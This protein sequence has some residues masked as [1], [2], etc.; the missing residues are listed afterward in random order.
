MGAVRRLVLSSFIACLVALGM[1]VSPVAANAAPGDIGYPGGSFTGL[2]NPPTADKPESKLWYN[3]GR[4]WADM[5]ETNSQD[6]HIFWLDRATEKWVDTGVAADD[7]MTSS[8]DTLWDGSKLYIASHIFRNTNEESTTGRPSRLYRYSYSTATQT[9]TL[10]AGFPTVINDVTSEALTLDKDST[11]KLWASWTQVTGVGA[12]ATAQVWIN[13]TNGTDGTWGTPF[14]VPATGGVNPAVA[15]DDISALVAFR[16]RVGVLWSDQMDGTVYWSV[17]QDADARDA[18]TGKIAI[19]GNAEADDHINIK[20]LQ[21]DQAGR[22]FAVTKT[23]KD[24]LS[25]SLSTDPLIRLLTFTPGTGNWTVSTVGTLA[26]CLTRPQLVLDETNQR[27][28]VVAT[29][30]TGAGEC[31]PTRSGSI[32]M[33]SS[34][35]TNPS[36]AGGSGTPIMRDAASDNLNN[37]TMTKQSVNASTGLV[38]VASNQATAQYW[39]ADIALG[40]ATGTP[41]SQFTASPAS[42]EAP[43]TVSFTDTSAGSPTSWAWNFGDGTTSAER[44]PV[45]TFTAAGSYSVTMTASNAAGAGTTTGSTITV[46]AGVQGDRSCITRSAP[47]SGIAL[48][49]NGSTMQAFGTGT[50]RQVWYR[51]VAQNAAGWRSLGG[52]SLYSPAAVTAGTT[53]YVMTV[54]SDGALWTRSDSGSGWGAWTSLGGRLTASPAVASLGSGHLRVFGRGGDNEL[55]T[56]EFTNGAWGAWTYLGGRITAAPVATAYT[57]AA[58]V[59]VSVRGTDGLVYTMNLARGAG[60]G[61]YTKRTFAACSTLSVPSV[62]TAAFAADRVYLDAAGTAW[63]GSTGTTSTVV[64]GHFASNPDVEKSGGANVVAGVG[65]DRQLW[66]YDPRS[67]GLGGWAALGGQFL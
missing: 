52:T 5:W 64:G 27:V 12:A 28:I 29:G 37:V 43:L 16:N 11:G 59:E 32:Y 61:T 57:S 54:G 8:S 60:A 4:W 56:R 66:V 49:N 2:N 55:W 42:G 7:R 30:P 6:W 63:T 1:L 39:H 51:T 62:S 31:T 26:D 9:Y 23:S 22:V 10:D 33:K 18:W 58:Q 15:P 47:A 50:D 44:N 19:R 41:T 65:S 13:S 21:S 40:S 38:V 48:A 35:M 36:F 25:S 24:T 34:P 46:G 3:D 67:G 20:S 17:H 14:V 53:A 45:H